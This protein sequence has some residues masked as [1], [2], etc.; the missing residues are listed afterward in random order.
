MRKE[1]EAVQIRR[2]EVIRLRGEGKSVAEAAKSLGIS[3]QT[4]YND[5]AMHERSLLREKG[6]DRELLGRML[7]E[8]DPEAEEG[9][10]EFN[11][12]MVMLAALGIGTHESSWGEIARR[13]GVPLAQVEGF[14]RRLTDQGVWRQGK[15]APTLGDWDDP[16]CF[17]SDVCVALGWLGVRRE[18]TG[19][20]GGA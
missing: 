12:G 7:R 16:I 11:A 17:W 18:A 4:A 6:P 13:T 1:S 8:S 15:T 5:V 19:N 14:A 3:Y 20:A 9:C 10:D 2:G